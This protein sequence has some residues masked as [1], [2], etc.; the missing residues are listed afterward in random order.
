MNSGRFA[1][2]APEIA[3]V[4]VDVGRVDASSPCARRRPS[5]RST[6]RVTDFASSAT[7]V[8]SV[9]LRA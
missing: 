3:V 2:S 5:P 9:D 4:R 1:N 6:W 8:W 7:P